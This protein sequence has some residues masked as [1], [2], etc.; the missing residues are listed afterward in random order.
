[1]PK[2]L[3]NISQSND[4]YSGEK[5]HD[6][7]EHYISGDHVN[8]TD[9]LSSIEQLNNYLQQLAQQPHTTE[10]LKSQHIIPLNVSALTE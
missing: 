2:K 10:L 8:V 6:L 9:A 5:L 7:L 1:M 3:S 4:W